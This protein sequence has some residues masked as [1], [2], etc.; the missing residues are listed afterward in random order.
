MLE[1]YLSSP[2]RDQQDRIDDLLESFQTGQNVWNK[3][4][5]EKDKVGRELLSRIEQRIL[6]KEPT[7]KLVLPGV[8]RV[9]A[10]IAIILSAALGF[11]LLNNPDRE[12]E[13]IAAVTK[14]TEY[15]QK[16]NMTLSDGTFVKLNSGSRLTF[17]ERFTADSRTVDLTGEAYFEVTPNS[18]MPFVVRSGEVT[19][20][21][22]G[23]RF[24]VNTFVPEKIR[25]T[26]A[27]GKVKVYGLPKNSANAGLSEVILN[28]KDQALY[29]ISTGELTQRVVN[30]DRVLAWKDGK[31]IF[32]DAT[33][34]EVATRLEK[35][36]GVEIEF[37][38]KSLEIC[39]LYNQFQD[40]SLVEV[41][42][43]LKLIAKI[44][45]LIEEGNRVIISGEGC[46]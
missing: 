23:T 42:D 13:E 43:E 4:L 27:E 12:A 18:E 16:L 25:V 11:W 2:D 38:D 39:T 1:Q 22:L 29:N 6:E 45:Y 14:I 5:G 19:T 44:D 17:P 46:N 8:L 33:L 24:N 3:E 26:V 21:V 30:I 41:L 35:W 37:A 7:R 20:T 10:S 9:A 36:Y 31:M 34:S 40:Q 28:A 15:G 32:E